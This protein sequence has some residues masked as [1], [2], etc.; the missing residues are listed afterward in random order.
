M[1]PVTRPAG[2][3]GRAGADRRHLGRRRAAGRRRARPTPT[4]SPPRRALPPTAGCGWPRSAPPRWSGSSEIGATADG[5]RWI[6]DFLSLTTALENSRK[7]QTYNTPAIATL[8]LLADQLDWMLEQ[9]GLDAMVARTTASSGHLYG[10]A[11]EPR[12]RHAVRRRPGQ[13]LAG[14]RHDRLRRRRRRRRAGGDAARQRDRRRRALS[15]ARGATSCG[16]RCSRPPTPTT[17]QALT[18]CIDWVLERS[19]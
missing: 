6:P 3:D 10:W 18:A 5:A 13:A 4:T 14:R 8:L 12:A 17:S 16:S 15:Q 7:D 1:V 19:A 2:S 11:D 9:G